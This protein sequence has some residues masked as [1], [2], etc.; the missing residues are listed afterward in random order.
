MKNAPTEHGALNYGTRDCFERIARFGA[1]RGRALEA[2]KTEKRENEAEAKAASGHADEVKL[3]EVE[4]RAVTKQDERDE[5]HDQ[6]HGD[7]FDPQHEAGGNF[8][9]ATRDDDRN[10]G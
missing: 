2:D 3:R 5:Q 9:V 7:G 4:V 8:D 6:A 10:R 1:E